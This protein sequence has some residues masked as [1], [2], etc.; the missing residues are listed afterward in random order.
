M[1]RGLLRTLKPE[2]YKNDSPK[3]NYSFDNISFYGI[4][5]PWIMLQDDRK[6][7][8]RRGEAANINVSNHSTIFQSE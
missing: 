4:C 2:S 7:K 1:V 6:Y 5:N 3:V 8:H